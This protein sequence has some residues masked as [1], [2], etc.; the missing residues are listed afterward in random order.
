VGLISKKT[1][2]KS[3]RYGQDTV[4]GGNSREPL[5][6]QSIP[7][8]FSDV[9]NTGGTDFLLRANALGASARDISRLT[10]L[11]TSTSRGRL[12]TAK[13]NVLSLTNV[14]SSVGYAPLLPPSIS[15]K[16]IFKSD[17]DTFLG[18]ALEIGSNLFQVGAQVGSFINSKVQ[19]IN[20]INQGIYSPTSTIAQAG[21]NALGTHLNKQGLNPFKNTTNFTVGGNLPLALPTYLNT[22]GG[23][24]IE[25]PKTRMEGLFIKQLGSSNPSDTN[26]ISYS[27][28]PG[29]TLGVGR[30]IIKVAPGQPSG[31]GSS[32]FFTAND[33]RYNSGNGNSVTNRF[34]LSQNEINLIT[35]VG[36][37][38]G[39]TYQNFSAPL[40]SQ[41]V[42]QSIP[43]DINPDLRMD[44]RVNLGDPGKRANRSSYV[45]GRRELNNN[46]GIRENLTYKNALDKLNALPIYQSA[47]DNS[48]VTIKDTN[49]LV[50]FR[51]GVINNNDPSKKT[52]IHFRA[53]IDS[54]SD[55]YSSEWEAQKFMGR[56]ENFYKYSGFD[57]QISLS[58]TVAAQ[59][60]QELIPMYQKL[61]YLASVCAPD[62]S[63]NGYMR[64]NL[65]SLTVGGWCYEQIGI[66]KGINLEVPTESP[67]EIGI[68][69]TIEAND[70]TVKELPMIVKVTGFTFVPIHNFVPKIQSN[71]YG[72]TNAAENEVGFI[73]Q[74]GDERYISLAAGSG[75]NYG[76]NPSNPT[77]APYKTLVKPLPPSLATPPITDRIPTSI[78]G[79]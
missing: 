5:V 28:G 42:P 3:L 26:L 31:R 61:N 57:R 54:M 45:I 60:K 77:Y 72:S 76:G 69:D 66:M 50:K 16:G 32:V 13:Q 36:L 62:Y 6:T 63:S 71:T 53:L 35:P 27:G 49:D 47:I 21:V 44:T 19:D 34:V 23:L 52:Y 79:V 40:V 46:K 22:I 20:P 11:L 29:A 7:N 58:W 64:G 10:Q 18:R 67:W 1:N 65:I 68:N 12:F 73:N 55:N 17:A 4:G 78:P 14:D 9:G 2:L 41:A 8:S 43:W 75:D 59:S 37:G 25:G 33:P 24:G 48:P 15:L 38:V 39:A 30:T 56:G 74:Y 70:S 51:I